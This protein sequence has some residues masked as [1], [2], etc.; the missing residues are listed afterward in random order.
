MERYLDSLHVQPAVRSLCVDLNREWEGLF[1]GPLDQQL[2]DELA[3]LEN[4]RLSPTKS[5]RR[6]ILISRV[7]FQLAIEQYSEHVRGLVRDMIF[8]VT[9]YTS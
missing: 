6:F 2:C 7:E 4:K 1:K 5:Q 8:K 3:L 9:N